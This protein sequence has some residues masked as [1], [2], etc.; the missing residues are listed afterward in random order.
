MGLIELGVVTV[1]FIVVVVGVL[2][3]SRRRRSFKRA[4]TFIK[5]HARIQDVRWV[6]NHEVRLITRLGPGRA[7]LV[8]TGGTDE[9]RA[10]LELDV[11]RRWSWLSLQPATLGEKL[12]Q[13]DVQ[14]GDPA[15]DGAWTIQSASTAAA[16]MA[17]RPAVRRCIEGLGVARMELKGR[18][19]LLQPADG[20]L[21]RPF[22]VKALALAELLSTGAWDQLAESLGLL[23]EA[24]GLL[25]GEVD[26]FPV[27]LELIHGER[28][29]LHIRVSSGLYAIHAKE[30]A[31]LGARP[32]QLNNPV[33]SGMVSLAG[34]PQLIERLDAGEPRLTE[35]LLQVV[36]GLP[37]SSVDPTGVRLEASTRAPD[38][39]GL[40]LEQGLRLAR[41]LEAPV[42]DS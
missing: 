19:L 34:S 27:R 2:A 3:S 5:G 18:R 37:G 22:V 42:Q 39:L 29:D 32:V 13:D 14:V 7:E 4:M 36:H 1:L 38:R 11:G 26:G 21:S 28:V 25:V 12:V 30:A 41:A 16:C 31:K 8:R 23:E 35:A 24:T 20:A 15:F 40:L 33:L 9:V 6:G 10:E 17:L